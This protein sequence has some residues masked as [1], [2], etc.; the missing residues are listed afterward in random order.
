MTLYINTTKIN[1]IN[2]AVKN[3]RDVLAEKK[4]VTKYPQS[5][6]ILV[7]IQKLLESKSIGLNQINK[8]QVEN[9]GESFTGLR[10]GVAVANALGYALSIK[11]NGSMRSKSKNTKKFNIIKPIYNKEPNIT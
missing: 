5:E 9:K 8:I 7:E 4:I 6:K 3:N 10:M 11:V 1:L 2:I